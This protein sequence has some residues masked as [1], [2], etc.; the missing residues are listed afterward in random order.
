[1][2][3]DDSVFGELG[4][5][6]ADP[7]GPS[8]DVLVHIPEFYPDHYPLSEEDIKNIR[9]RGHTFA[10]ELARIFDRL[11]VL[12]LLHRLYKHAAKWNS[13]PFLPDWARDD[14]PCYPHR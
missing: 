5:F 9:D 10:G 3:M 2:V 14:C 12:P 1:M 7:I 11:F 8:V 4:R 6:L 13:A